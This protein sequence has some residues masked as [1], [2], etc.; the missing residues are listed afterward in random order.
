MASRKLLFYALLAAATLGLS[1]FLAAW[2]A[3]RTAP[4]VEA[5][6]HVLVLGAGLLAVGLWLGFILYEVD[7]AAGRVHRRI[8]LYEWVLARRSAARRGGP[9][10]ATDGGGGA[11]PSAPQ[12]GGGRQR[13]AG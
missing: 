6:A 9:W 1:Q 10:Q 5:G 8:M 11:A 4:G 3:W 7:R 12:I 13:R 2:R